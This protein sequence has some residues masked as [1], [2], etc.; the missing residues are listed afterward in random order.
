MII[1]KNEFGCG[2]HYRGK[3]RSGKYSINTHIHQFCEIIYV[4][5]GEVALSVDDNDY[6]LTEGYAAVITPFQ[7]HSISVE[8]ADFWM[9]VFSNNCVPNYFIDVDMFHNRDCSV[10]KAS[11]SLDAQIKTIRKKVAHP[12]HIANGTVPRPIKA[13]I[14]SAFTEY[15]EA[16]PNVISFKKRDTL[17][18]L[19]V[20][21]Y[22]HYL[23]NISLKSIGKELGYNPKYLSQC[24]MTIPNMSFPTILNSL[25]TDH[26]KN[27]LIGTNMKISAIA[28]ECGYSS[29][30]T[31][32]RTFLKIAGMTP[33]EYRKNA[34]RR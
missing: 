2:E 28:Y 32:H 33:T 5:R 12:I 11:K 14:Y 3:F 9:C 30:Q 31:F 18:A 17:S 25:R 20:Y 24:L 19:F 16:V 15:I 23:E 22:E 21:I 8:N 34:F 10:F 29:E 7:S 1:F 13:V 27:L 4:T 6:T 26:A